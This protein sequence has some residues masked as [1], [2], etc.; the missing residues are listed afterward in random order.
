[1]QTE[2]LRAPPIWCSDFIMQSNVMFRLSTCRSALTGSILFP[3]QHSWRMTAMFFALPQQ[4]TTAP[5]R[6]ATRP[7]TSTSSVSVHFRTAHGNWLLI[8]TTAKTWMWLRPEP[9]TPLPWAVDIPS[10]PVRHWLLRLW[11][12]SF[13]CCRKRSPILHLTRFMSC[14]LRPRT[15][16]AT[17]AMTITTATVQSMP[18]RCSLRSAGPLHTT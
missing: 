18:R 14:S 9:F 3:K 13:R 6:F 2:A 11:Q 12:V 10:R 5:R 7:P 15:T 17:S 8:P 16:L 4:A 1:M